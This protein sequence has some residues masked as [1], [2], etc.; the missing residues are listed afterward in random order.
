MEKE[1][2]FSLQT[3]AGCVRVLLICL[4]V[5]LLFSCIAQMISSN[6]AK[7]KIEEISIDARGAVLQADLY[8][9]AGVTDR[10]KLPA[11]I[12]AHG[13]GVTKGNYRGIVE[14]LA[15]RGFVVM[16]INGYAT[17]F[18]EMPVY[19]ESNMGIDAYVTNSSSSGTVDALNF[20]RS[21]K[22]VDATRIG[23]AGHS[24]GSRRME[25]AAI[26]DNGYLSFNDIMLNVLY[27]QFGKEISE[28][29]LA[30]NADELA[31]AKLAPE[32]MD[33]YNYIRA[34]KEEWFNTRPR[35][36]C[37]IGGDAP[38]TK[39]LKEVEVA[40]HT[41]M[42]NIRINRAIVNGTFDR[43]GF[44]LTPAYADA[45]YPTAELQPDKW[46][47]VDDLTQSNE[48]VGDFSAAAAGNAKLQAALDARC[49]RMFTLNVESHSKNFFS[50]Q[51]AAD[52]VK[53]FEDTLSIDG[54]P[55]GAN[56]GHFVWREI[57][58]AIAMIAML[59]ALVP[60]A[61]L[62][63][64]TAFFAP[65]LGE[66]KVAPLTYTKKRYWILNGVAVVIGII[67]TLVLDKVAEQPWMYFH[68][69]QLHPLFFSWWMVPIFLGVIAVLSLIEVIV[70]S[71]IDKKNGES[72][73]AN[74]N[75]LIK[76]PAILK[77]LL[78]ALIVIIAAY[79]SLTM[80]T[81]LFNQDYRLWM[82]ALPQLKVEHW[83]FVIRLALLFLPSTIMC[84]LALNYAPKTGK[85]EFADD[86]LAVLV[87]SLGV[88]IICFIDALLMG[89]NGAKWTFTYGY[90]FSVPV[91]NYVSRRLFR[92]TRNVWIGA[93]VAAL[94]L[95][96][97]LVGTMGYDVYFAQNFGSIFFNN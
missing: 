49:A 44:Y 95:A 75:L 59:T 34:E 35:A 93:A 29:E 47:A 46:Y 24:Q 53:Y 3:K 15:R 94:L 64:G 91:V 17:G 97:L 96:W 13:A 41:V 11:V 4:C 30:E 2:R 37:L 28:E 58:N 78:L 54:A 67:A 89:K 85:G 55:A 12:F 32:E 9:P 80:I 23:L 57:C 62:L 6:G 88:W 77:S 84:G 76:I 14:E 39:A 7:I 36:L 72:K 51:T 21:L 52:V 87:N 22:F 40:G 65:C 45:Y 1:K 38:N 48:I 5:I 74:T 61:K 25:M 33:L 69:T 43:V 10:D 73:F 82:F 79:A 68:A 56:T 70:L 60:L 8:Y 27:E 86:M 18:S 81:Y 20:V 63:C 16:N 26:L 90:I 66:E 19:D 31:A 50:V 71:V 42:R 83:W 92:S